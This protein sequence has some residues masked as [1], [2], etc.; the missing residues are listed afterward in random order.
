[1]RGITQNETKLKATVKGIKEE[2]SKKLLHVD[3]V[4]FYSARSRLLL[5]KGLSDL[6][7]E[8]AQA[9]TADVERLLELVEGYKKAEEY[10][11]VT[12]KDIA[13]ANDI[14]GDI[15]GRS[16]DELSPSSRKLLD[17][18]REMAEEACHEKKIPTKEDR[19]NRRDIREYSGWSDFQIRTHIRQLEELE[20]IY[21]VS[22]KRGKEY[23]Y[24]LIYTGGGEEGTPFLMGLIDIE[25]LKKKAEEAGII[26]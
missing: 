22:G 17:L 16:L 19:F 9:I 21:P 26:D 8:D 6:F 5:I 24:E 11:N 20:Y 23:I 13:M 7:G 2:K 12:L 14:A 18:I 10:I 25:K 3:T 1:M 4:D 15:L